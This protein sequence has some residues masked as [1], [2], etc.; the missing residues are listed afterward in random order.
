MGKLNTEAQWIFECS[1]KEHKEW[2]RKRERTHI[3]IK[4]EKH[5]EK[6][7][8][9]QKAAAIAVCRAHN[10]NKIHGKYSD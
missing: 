9:S 7:R 1:E 6:E 5:W 3:H 10:N 2:E 4:G 8:I